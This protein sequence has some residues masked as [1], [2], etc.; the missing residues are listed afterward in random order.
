M[1]KGVPYWCARSTA[2]ERPGDLDSD[3]LRLLL[4]KR[5]NPG[6]GQ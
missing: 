2:M 6:H 3:E 1:K 5:F 4:S